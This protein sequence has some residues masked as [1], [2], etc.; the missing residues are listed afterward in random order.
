MP[1]TSQVSQSV[2]ADCTFQRGGKGSRELQRTGP[3]SPPDKE[4]ESDEL[5]E[6]VDDVPLAPC[7]KKKKKMRVREESYKAAERSKAQVT[8]EK[9]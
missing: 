8:R 6:L 9:I 7:L 1:Q 4:E 2:G 3:E 5:L